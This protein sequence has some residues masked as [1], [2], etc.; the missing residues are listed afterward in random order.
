MQLTT[1]SSTPSMYW[2]PLAFN[3]WIWELKNFWLFCSTAHII[4]PV[5]LNY[6]VLCL[7]FWLQGMQLTID[8]S[9]PR[10]V[11]WHKDGIVEFV[12]SRAFV[13]YAKLHITLPDWVFIA[14]L[15]HMGK[16]PIQQ[17]LGYFWLWSWPLLWWRS[18]LGAYL[19]PLFSLSAP[20]IRLTIPR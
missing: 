15:A 4:C 5:N 12:S 7:L 8:S 20:D 10:Y 2:L 9:A 3:I 18:G 1:N 17:N 14:H 11:D 16:D 6:H 13:W 19:N